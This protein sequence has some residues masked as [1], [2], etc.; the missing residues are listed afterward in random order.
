MNSRTARSH[1]RF[2]SADIAIAMSVEFSDERDNGVVG[3]FEEIDGLGALDTTAPGRMPGVHKHTNLE[4]KRGVMGRLV[5]R[6][7]LARRNSW[8]SELKRTPSASRVFPM[9]PFGPG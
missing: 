8:S 1:V 2:G 5:G 6:V 4:L 7:W 9:C 3:G